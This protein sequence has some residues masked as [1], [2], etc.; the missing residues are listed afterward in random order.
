MMTIKTTQP[1]EQEELFSVKLCNEDVAVTSKPGLPDWDRLLPS[2]QLLAEYPKLQPLDR[3]LLFGCHNGA[4]SVSIARHLP[5]GRLTIIDNNIIALDMTR[6]TLA[7]NNI[8][9]VSLLNNIDL[10]QDRIQSYD[11]VFIQIPKGRILT[12]RWL[13]QAFQGLIPGKYL[14]ISGSNKAGI[15]SSI[16]D[17]MELFGNGRI[18]AY[19]KG[20]RISQYVKQQEASSS[21]DW[22]LA[23]GIKPG[24]WFEFSITLSD[25]KYKI[26]SLPGVFSYD[27]L[28]AGTQMILSTFSV[29]PGSKVLDV[30]CGYGLI[31]LVAST[32]G[33]GWVDFIDNDL[34]AISSCK[35]T[36]ALN[37]IMNTNV[38]AGDL[39]GP[40]RSN[41]YDLILSN[42]PFHAG[43]AV[44]YQIAEAMIRQSYQALHSDGQ[45]TIVA[46]RFIPYDRLINDIFGNVSC[47]IESG[48]FHVL[49]GKK[50]GRDY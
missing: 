23:P 1:Y 25:H 7:A 38:L 5:L 49:S 22:A 35:E 9:S 10:P 40:V 39:L 46:N 44:D 50:T 3:V 18:L 24:T 33:A 37:G 48:R 28:D 34:L 36:L 32:Q 20:N 12:R 26:R 17:G 31:G 43:H 47:L 27:H 41:K 16:K 30:G 29:K 21:P 45:I 42:P 11:A 2:T 15:Q 13:L 14:Y 6:K 19:K 4:L 8:S